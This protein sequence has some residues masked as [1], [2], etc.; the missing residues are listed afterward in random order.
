MSTKLIDLNQDLKRLRSEGYDIGIQEGHL[1]VRD[2]PYLDETGVI[3]LAVLL[4]PLRLAGDSTVQPDS[5]TVLFTGEYPHSADGSRLASIECGGR[6]ERIVAG[7]TVCYEFSAHKMDKGDNKVPYQDYYE[8]MTSYVRRISHP[9][10]SVDPGATAKTHRVSDSINDDY[11]F[12]YLETASARA[13]ISEMQAKLVD[14]RLGIVGV[15]GTGSYILDFVAKTPVREIHLFDD[16]LFL[17]HNAFR[18]PGAASKTEL[19]ACQ[20]KVE[21]FRNK[22]K[23]QKRRIISHKERI[24]S[25]NLD[26]LN[27]LD[28]IFI[29]LD[30]GHGKKEIITHLEEYKKPFIDVGIGVTSVNGMLRGSI[31]TTASTNSCRDHIRENNRISLTGAPVE[32]EYSRNTQIVELNALNAALA[33]IKWKKIVEFYLD[34]SREHNSM[35]LLGQNHI[36]NQDIQKE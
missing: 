31:R 29:C 15:G 20:H 10:A 6:N 13:G 11:P 36:V 24:T 17:S 28:F 26:C 34:Q 23:V 18:S 25:E 32:D 8:K 16:D 9:A 30:A 7:L 35:Y 1:L 22:Y 21:Y 12:E 4:S 33:V 3:R 19:H 14:Y 27:D 2:V 5:H